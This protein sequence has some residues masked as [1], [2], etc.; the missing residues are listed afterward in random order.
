MSG[1]TTLAK[2][3]VQ[4]TIACSEEVDLFLNDIRDNHASDSPRSVHRFENG[5]VNVDFVLESNESEIAS[6]ANSY[7]QSKRFAEVIDIYLIVLDHYQ[8]QFG[9]QYPFVITTRKC[10]TFFNSL[11]T[12][13]FHFNILF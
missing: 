12:M 7:I 5:P 8:K 11:E 4:E 2:D 3:R 9:Q 13:H 1:Q 6:F 10:P